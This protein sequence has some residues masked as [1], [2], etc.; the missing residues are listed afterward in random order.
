M[1]AQTA[2]YKWSLNLQICF[3][4]KFYLADLTRLGQDLHPRLG[5]R[6]LPAHPIKMSNFGDGSTEVYLN[7]KFQ[8]KHFNSSMAYLIKS[9]N[10]ILSYYYLTGQRFVLNLLYYVIAIP[11][12]TNVTSVEPHPILRRLLI[13]L[14]CGLCCSWTELAELNAMILTAGTFIGISSRQ[15]IVIICK[16]TNAFRY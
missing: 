12:L 16:K 14:S 4:W 15:N 6:P 11:W 8:W 10:Y 9:V 13:Y 5:P 7:N 2:L 3:L 1:L